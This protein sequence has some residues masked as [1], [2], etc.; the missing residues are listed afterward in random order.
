[1]LD[2]LAVGIGGFVGSVG[3][4]LAG[5]IPIPNPE[6]FPVNT[7]L[8]NILGSFVIGCLAAL[9]AQNVQ[10]NPRLMLFL[11][12]GIC[13]GFTTFS[14]F[15]LETSELIRS[16]AYGAAVLYVG[17]SAGLGIAA[18]ILAQYLVR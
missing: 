1:M 18:V 15:S 2:C 16:G 17:L 12:V 14:T 4:Y 5:K 8:I 3:R 6:G 9:T 11:K 7:L 10:L 13:G